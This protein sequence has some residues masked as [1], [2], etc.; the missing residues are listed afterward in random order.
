M[1]LY[2]LI[3]VQLSCQLW[4]LAVFFSTLICIISITACHPFPVRSRAGAALRQPNR[5]PPGFA[6]SLRVH[7][8]SEQPGER[9]R[10]G[11][12]PQ[13]RAGL[14]VRR[15]AWPHH[16]GKPQRL[17]CGG[18]GLH[19]PGEP[20]WVQIQGNRLINH[21]HNLVISAVSY[22][23]IFCSPS[24]HSWPSLRGQ[25]ESIINSFITMFL[26]SSFPSNFPCPCVCLPHFLLSLRLNVMLLNLFF[27]SI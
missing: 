21:V 7:P 16:E 24:I 18:G 3:A 23:K 26:D 2:L 8:A 4:P 20:R 10:P 19:W 27:G 13:P 9:H 25:H 6:A 14:L 22:L 15:D 5:H 11:L 17:Q 1:F 12:P